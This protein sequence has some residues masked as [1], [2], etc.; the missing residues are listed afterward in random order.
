MTR[1][2]GLF[3][4]GEHSDRSQ[5]LER[6]ASL[7]G[8]HAV[9]VTGAGSRPSGRIN[10]RTVRFAAGRGLDL[11]WHASQP[12]ENASG[13]GGATITIGGGDGCPWLPP[14]RCEDWVLPDPRGMDDDGYRVVRHKVKARVA[15]PLASL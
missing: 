9:E 2:R 12:L 7:R 3:N 13:R 8:D 6:L 1:R 5:M 11:T 10:P 15:A 4:Y 14:T